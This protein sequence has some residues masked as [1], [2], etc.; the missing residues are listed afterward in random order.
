MIVEFTFINMGPKKKGKKGGK[1]K[2]SGSG[3]K[4]EP[5]NVLTFTEAVMMHQ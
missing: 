5:A 4:K 1:G 2:K 3:K